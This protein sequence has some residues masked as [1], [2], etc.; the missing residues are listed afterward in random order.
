MLKPD[1]SL[2]TMTGGELILPGTLNSAGFDAEAIARLIGRQTADTAK[3]L[4]AAVK[5]HLPPKVSTTLN[6]DRTLL[7]VKRRPE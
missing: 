6:R 1:E 5:M 2:V 4:T 3:Q 7:I